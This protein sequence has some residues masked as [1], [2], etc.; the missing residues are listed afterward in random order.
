LGYHQAFG[1]LLRL[2]FEIILKLTRS[3]NLVEASAESAVFSPVMV[4]ITRKNPC[5]YRAFHGFEQARFSYDGLILDSSQ[6]S[7]LPQLNPK[8]CSIQVVKIIPKNHL[9][10]LI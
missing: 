10:T 9:A 1:K 4:T 5:F 7:I 6:F 8:K 2:G 3:A